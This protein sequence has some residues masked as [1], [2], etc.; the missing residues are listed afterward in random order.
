[1]KRYIFLLG[2]LG[3]AALFEACNDFDNTFDFTPKVQFSIGD[4]TIFESEL[5]IPV[6]V[7]LVG[8][9]ISS[10]VTVGWEVG[11]SALVDRGL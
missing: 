8:P 3:F 6:D 4:T 7:Q 9:Q 5:T 1:M 2:L 10:P 11:G